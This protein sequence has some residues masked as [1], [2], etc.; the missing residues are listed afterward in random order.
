MINEKPNITFGDNTFTR[1]EEFRRAKG[2]PLFSAE[3]GG[4]KDFASFLSS[5][6]K[7]PLLVSPNKISDKSAQQPP[8]FSMPNSNKAGLL[9]LQGPFPSP[10]G[11]GGTANAPR[12]DTAPKD[13][14]AQGAR[15]AKQPAHGEGAAQKPA[16][17][18]TAS[19]N[20][21]LT[22]AMQ[23][24]A[25]R[26]ERT[27]RKRVSTLSGR[28]AFGMEDTR[29]AARNRQAANTAQQNVDPKTLARV[30]QNSPAPLRTLNSMPDSARLAAS[31]S[32]AT[33]PATPKA[34]VITFEQEKYPHLL[35]DKTARNEGLRLDSALLSGDSTQAL[36]QA[37]RDLGPVNNNFLALNPHLNP[38]KASP[39]LAKK[40]PS[41][42]VTDAMFAQNAIA[43]GKGKRALA[44]KGELGTLAAKFE[45]GDMG[46]AAI[47]YDRHGGTSYGKYQISS[48]AGT[49]QN[50]IDYLEE[51]APELARELS[52]AGPA[53]T[54]SR[55]GRMP[56]VWQQIAGREPERFETLQNEFIKTS[57]YEPALN[58]I[59]QSTGVSATALPKALQEVLFS[60]AVQHGP[61][62]AASIVSRA[63]TQVGAN[64]LTNTA[65][66][67][68]SPEGKNSGTAQKTPEQE[69]IRQIYTLRS[70][71]FGSSTSQVRSAV[72]NRLKHEMQD[73][74]TLL[75]AEAATP[76]QT[77][78]SANALAGL[79]PRLV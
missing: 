52:A 20:L 57:H 18:L 4:V 55:S 63:V 38:G 10:P 2:R 73:A 8:S 23:T 19:D 7:S 61:A 40:L 24:S 9:S 51:K 31:S 75:Q 71:Q 54:G 33:G 37:F 27:G 39:P 74:L 53:N 67:A 48:R 60:T 42:G 70:R 11:A 15:Q 17:L 79:R 14:A 68:S 58:A 66:A 30:L 50:F 78:A 43:S 62:G 49:M 46:I 59:A 45:S 65:L 34:P 69:L 5:E 44:H 21:A 25:E 29:P 12:P 22:Q 6:N 36:L 1:G 47:G 26:G 77:L 13:R 3:Q 32:G 16:S 64:K 41:N 72:Q 76:P 56:G 28:P 35:L